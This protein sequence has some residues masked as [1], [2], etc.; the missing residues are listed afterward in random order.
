MGE[1]RTLGPSFQR[2][3]LLLSEASGL[4]NPARHSSVEAPYVE[5]RVFEIGQIC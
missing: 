2:R 5:S 1:R 4:T 3:L